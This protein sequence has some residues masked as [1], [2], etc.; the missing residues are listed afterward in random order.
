MRVHRL[1]TGNQATESLASRL[2]IILNEKYEDAYVLEKGGNVIL[3]GAGRVYPADIT[4]FL[5]KNSSNSVPDFIAH[6]DAQSCGN[7]TD[8]SDW[9]KDFGEAGV[10]EFW[11]IY[12]RDRIVVK[13]LLNN[14]GIF[15]KPEI[16]SE[17][18]RIPVSSVPEL[19][20]IGR[21]L[22]YGA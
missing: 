7:M 11:L 15:G 22:F 21:E 13:R 14:E 5:N 20:V 16:Y 4:L 9:I 2:T 3:P 19:S 12:P 8:F 6:V 1:R 18:D 10:K 17:E